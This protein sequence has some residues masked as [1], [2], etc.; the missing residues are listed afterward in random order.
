MNTYISQTIDIVVYNYFKNLEPTKM[1][2]SSFTVPVMFT[3][4]FHKRKEVNETISHLV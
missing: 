1:D 2:V 3:I 4:S